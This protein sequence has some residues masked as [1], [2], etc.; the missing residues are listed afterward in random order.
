MVRYIEAPAVCSKA[1]WFIEAR[2][3]VPM[4]YVGDVSGLRR[5]F[6]AMEEGTLIAL[7]II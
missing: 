4:H 5:F 3:G 1:M 2:A 7:K 6:Q